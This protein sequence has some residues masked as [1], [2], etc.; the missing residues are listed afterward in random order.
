M[1]SAGG[2]DPQAESMS[3]M[4]MPML[5][6]MLM[7]V[8]LML[9]PSL[10][11]LLADGAG[12][13]IE[14]MLPFHTAYF[15]PTVFIVG[16]SIMIVNTIIRAFFTDPLSQAHISH[17]QKQIG[18]QLRE[19]QMARD[20]AR[21]E[22]M[23]KM[24]MSM[25]P[26]QMAMQAAM[27]RPMMFTM[28]FIIAIFSWMASEVESF[29]V[30]FV[31]LPWA[32]MWSFNERIMWIFPAWIAT[33]ITMSAP[34]GRII[35]RH[36]KIRRYR[37]HPLVL[38][39]DPIPEPLIHLLGEQ[40]VKTS[41]DSRTRRAQ[42]RRNGPRKKGGQAMTPSQKKRGNTPIAP[43]KSGTVCPSCNSEMV[44]RTAKGRLR[45]DMCRNEWR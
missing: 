13:A 29:R 28:V 41:D 25:Q 15:V 5:F 38:S 34:L 20:T 26:E 19:A 33:Y 31:S 32:P 39:G 30:S 18:K 16:S 6:L 22:K 7:M 42:R 2:G 45:C 27:M 3:S 44:T 8:V 43:P 9:N 21:T 35:D 14:P 10:R 12:Y 24:Q 36:I 17:R 1:T 4:M 40:K 11:I 37:S 23:Q